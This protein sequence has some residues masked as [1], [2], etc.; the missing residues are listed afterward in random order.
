MTDP[1]IPEVF[2]DF[3]LAASADG[4][5]AVADSGWQTTAT[6]TVPPGSLHDERDLLRHRAR[7]DH[8]T[9]WNL[10]PGDLGYVPPAYRPNPAVVFTVHERLPA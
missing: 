2:Y 5:G 4:T 1:D 3:R 6:W 9:R 8:R 10:T 7:L